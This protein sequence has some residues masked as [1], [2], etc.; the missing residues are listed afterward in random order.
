MPTNWCIDQK[1]EPSNEDSSVRDQTQIQR[2]CLT[3]DIRIRGYLRSLTY[4][5]QQCDR[6]SI[7][8]A[9]KKLC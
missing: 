7:N 3:S 5:R 2:M 6:P 1:V 9:K 4:S 8:V